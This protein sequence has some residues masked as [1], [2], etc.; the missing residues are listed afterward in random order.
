MFVSGP[1]HAS[2]GPDRFSMV[3]DTFT[4]NIASTWDATMPAD[5]DF[6]RKKL[7]GQIKLHKLKWPPNH[8]LPLFGDHAC[9]RILSPYILPLVVETQLLVALHSRAILRRAECDRRFLTIWAPKLSDQCGTVFVRFHS[10]DTIQKP[11]V[12]MD[13]QWYCLPHFQIC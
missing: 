11:S 8:G 9:A 10:A 3:L 1:C 2:S 7:G 12:A 5:V 6:V 13:V 4:A